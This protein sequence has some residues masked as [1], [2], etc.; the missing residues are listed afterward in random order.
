MA[1]DIAKALRWTYDHAQDFGGDS[2]KIYVMGH[3]AGAHLA[4][5]ICTDDRYLKAEGLSFSILKGCVAVD[6]AAYDVPK[7][8]KDSGTPQPAGFL[9]VFGSTDASHRELSPATYVAP[10]KNI[11]PFLILYVAGRA[12][13]KAQSH[14]FAE[15]LTE[16]SVSAKIVAAQGKT[17]ATINSDLG[18]PDD[19]P[20]AEV[21]AFLASPK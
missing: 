16:T 17:H 7:R 10:G 12:E 13:S 9:A 11:P 5:L 18:L 21:F 6:V 8:L 15:K 19:K 2:Q 14:W 1:G 4:A 20:T 3:S